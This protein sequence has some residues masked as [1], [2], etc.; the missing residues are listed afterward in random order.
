[1]GA[2][3]R[4][5]FMGGFECSTHV[6]R[7]GVRLD[8][9]RSTRHDQFAAADYARMRA[10]GMDTARDGV[11]WHLV[12]ASPGRYE[13]DSLM[14]MVKAALETDI[15]VVWDLLHFGWPDHVDV[16]DATFAPR[17]AAFAHAFAD[18]MKHEGVTELA[19]CP[20]NEISFL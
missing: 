1:M 7:D 3:F 16:F 19:V 6:R 4:S 14:P 13:F 5:F 2:I 12:E 20:V 9:L 18:R 15:Q 8:C 11:R 10:I 17:F